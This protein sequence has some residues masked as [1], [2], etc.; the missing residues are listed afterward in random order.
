MQDQDCEFNA[1]RVAMFHS[2]Y[3]TE[4]F[5]RFQLALER[6]DYRAREKN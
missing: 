5:Q 3:G 4:E 6:R 1:C 2:I